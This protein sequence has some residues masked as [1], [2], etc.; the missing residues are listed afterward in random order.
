MA[1]PGRPRRIFT[2]SEQ[3]RMVALYATMGMERVARQ[4]K[5]CRRRV[6]EILVANDVRLRPPWRRCCHI[7]RTQIGQQWAA[8]FC[9]EGKCEIPESGT[10]LAAFEKWRPT[11][12]RRVHDV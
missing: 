11:M 7:C 5:T 8:Q 10:M 3:A 9:E 6:R 1:S 4:I 12:K 2:Q